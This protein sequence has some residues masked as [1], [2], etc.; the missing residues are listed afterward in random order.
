MM[1][2]H[3]FHRLNRIIK[4][5]KELYS[6]LYSS[7]GS[8][9]KLVPFEYDIDGETIIVQK[10]EFSIK[11]YRNCFA[12]IDFHREERP[13]NEYFLYVCK[14]NILGTDDEI[15]DISFFDLQSLVSICKNFFVSTETKEKVSKPV[16]CEVRIGHGG[17]FYAKPLD[18]K[19]DISSYEISNYLN[20]PKNKKYECLL[21]K[22]LDQDWNFKKDKYSAY[23][24]DSGYDV[25]LMDFPTRCEFYIDRK[26]EIYY[27]MNDEVFKNGFRYLNF[28]DLKRH[29]YIHTLSVLKDRYS[30]EEIKYCL[31]YFF[32]KQNDSYNEKKN[33]FLYKAFTNLEKWTHFCTFTYDDKLLREDEFEKTLKTFFRNASYKYGI[34]V[35]GAFERSI[36]GRLH[37]HCLMQLTY[38]FLDDMKIITE[39]YYEKDKGRIRRSPISQTLKEKIGRCEFVKLYPE[40]ADF[41]KIVLYVVKYTS[42]AIRSVY[43]SRGLD[44]IKFGQVLNF[45]DHVIG[46]YSPNSKFCVMDD[47]S[48]FLEGGQYGGLSL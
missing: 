7:F 30:P 8:D 29:L 21:N 46:T 4:K 19:S 23:I 42:K 36:E 17:K 13:E 33:R 26:S 43:S 47:E 34:L 14:T 20:D 39:E 28:K 32:D 24:S 16:P 37:F 22:S 44:S 12:F 1:L 41:S 25:N 9:L 31:Q 3:I 40:Q 15:H 48:V 45:D 10:L 11:G 2:H 5:N 6:S 27:V 35:H 18:L 38:P